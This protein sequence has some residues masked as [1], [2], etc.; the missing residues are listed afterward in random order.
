MKTMIFSFLS[1]ILFS[2]TAFSVD[3]SIKKF[4]RDPFFPPSVSNDRTL[5]SVTRLCPPSLEVS[6]VAFGSSQRPI[7]F[8]KSKLY[9]VGDAFGGYV[10]TYIK[11]NKLQLKKTGY[12]CI[13]TFE[14]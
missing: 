4:K 3:S 14:N 2:T 6:G 1:I 11:K 10:I 8:I 7:V 12:V 9:S 13:H 5:Q